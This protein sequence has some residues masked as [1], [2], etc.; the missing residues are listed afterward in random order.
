MYLKRY[1]LDTK[2]GPD[3]PP[4][5]PEQARQLGLSERHWDRILNQSQP[6]TPR[7]RARIASRFSLSGEALDSIFETRP[8]PEKRTD[9]LTFKEFCAGLGKLGAHLKYNDQFLKSVTKM[10]ATVGGSKSRLEN[11][12]L[13]FLVFYGDAKVVAFNAMKA[14]PG[15]ECPG[16]YVGP[17]PNFNLGRVSAVMLQRRD[18]AIQQ[19]DVFSTNLVPLENPTRCD[20]LLI[21]LFE[22]DLPSEG[23]WITQERQRYEPAASGQMRFT[24]ASISPFKNMSLA[25]MSAQDPKAID[26]TLC[27]HPVQLP[28]QTPHP[29]HTEALEKWF[30]TLDSYL[31]LPAHSKD[32]KV[33]EFLRR[34]LQVIQPRAASKKRTFK[35]IH[36]FCPYHQY[37]QIDDLSDPVILTFHFSNP[38]SPQPPR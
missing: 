20:A 5:K 19:V 18:D 3:G 38:R 15:P 21:A 17:A 24:L 16:I 11:L 22:D 7:V 1:I 36:E 9:G 27:F 28:P 29:K 35:A 14:I 6:V 25:K 32:D 37:I 34:C 12:E 10:L 8:T 23:D 31:S 2:W 26:D 13:D 33:S 4:K 30:S